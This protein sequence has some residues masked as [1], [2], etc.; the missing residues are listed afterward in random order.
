M[1]AM[2][3]T[4]TPPPRWAVRAAHLVS[5]VVLPSALWRLPLVFGFS[6]GALEHG[7]PIEIPVRERFYILGLSVVTE[8]AA[9]STLGLVRPWGERFPPRLVLG[10]ASFGVVA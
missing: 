7:V 4:R 8:L 1:A 5:L 9:L 3:C 2:T 6:M 10:L